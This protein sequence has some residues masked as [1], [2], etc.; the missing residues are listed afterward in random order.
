MARCPVLHGVDA[1]GKDMA[2]V[3]GIRAAIARVN[4]TGRAV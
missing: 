1:D 2:Q 3:A 4:V